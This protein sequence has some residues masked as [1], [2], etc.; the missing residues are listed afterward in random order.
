MQFCVGAA[1][2]FEWFGW[3]YRVAVVA[4]IVIALHRCYS[5]LCSYRSI[6][7]ESRAFTNARPHD[8]H[9]ISQ[10]LTTSFHFIFIFICSYLYR[11][12][13]ILIKTIMLLQFYCHPENG[14]KNIENEKHCIQAYISHC[15]SKWTQS[16]QNKNQRKKSSTVS[17]PVFKLLIWTHWFESD[18]EIMKK[19]RKKQSAETL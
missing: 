11:S 10:P 6:E 15:T 12:V 5:T 17:F 8:M 2:H 19:R 7:S 13:T 1:W 14:A 4:I 16:W 3:R 18:C 9:N